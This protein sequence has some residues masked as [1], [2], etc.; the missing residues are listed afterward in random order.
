MGVTGWTVV[1]KGERFQ[2]EI[3]AAALVAEGL[4]AEVFGDSAYG[5]GIN[6]TEARLMVPDE[7]A[8]SA[9]RVIRQAESKPSEQ[10]DE[11]V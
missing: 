4:R 6:L 10:P 2:A 5:V 1:Y 3:I 8:E 9:R 11:E 7:Q